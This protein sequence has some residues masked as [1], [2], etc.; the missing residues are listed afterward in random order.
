MD[1]IKQQLKQWFDDNLHRGDIVLYRGDVLFVWEG[2]DKVEVEC[3]QGWRSKG[4]D[5]V[6]GASLYASGMEFC[7]NGRCRKRHIKNGGTRM[8]WLTLTEIKEG[9]IELSRIFKKI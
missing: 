2:L 3:V 7:D 6:I 1:N 8:I 4:K 5:E 9:A